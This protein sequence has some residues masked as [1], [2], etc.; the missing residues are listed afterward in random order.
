MKEQIKNRYDELIKLIEQANY[1]YYTLDNPT[2]TD[3][4]YDDLMSE[5]LSIEEKYP[6][7]KRADSPSEKIGG[8]II[9]EFAKVN[10]KVPMFSIA[11][12]FNEAEIVNF[13]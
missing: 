7:I 9:S 13:I 11:D 1:E 2:L 5:L 4:E 3:K 6:E 12:V 10:H 8:E